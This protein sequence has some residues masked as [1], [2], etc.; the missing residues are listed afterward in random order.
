MGHITIVPLDTHVFLTSSNDWTHQP[1]FGRQGML[2]HYDNIA[3]SDAV[4]ITNFDKNG[5]KG[6]I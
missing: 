4:L 3:S 2:A 5:I 6:Y 1:D